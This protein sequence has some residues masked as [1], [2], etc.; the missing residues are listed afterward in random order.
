MRK[1]D[2][3]YKDLRHEVPWVK[4]MPSDIVCEHLCFTTQPLE[5]LKKVGNDAND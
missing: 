4:R 3:Q 2:Q 5:E 1:M